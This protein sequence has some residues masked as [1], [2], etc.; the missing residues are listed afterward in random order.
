MTFGPRVFISENIL[1][2][3]EGRYIGQFPLK[4]KI[5]KREEKQ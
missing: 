1:L 5:S 4:R 3:G 2:P